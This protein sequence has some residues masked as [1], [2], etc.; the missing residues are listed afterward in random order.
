MLR[1]VSAAQR[2]I[3]EPLGKGEHTGSPLRVAVSRHRSVGIARLKRLGIKENEHGINQKIA[4]ANLFMPYGY[5][6]PWDI[7]ADLK[8]RPARVQGL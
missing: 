8:P 2:V 3:G 7:G 5:L 4:G 6:C 1:P